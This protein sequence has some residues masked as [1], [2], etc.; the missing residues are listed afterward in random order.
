MR[1]KL[2]LLFTDVEVEESGPTEEDIG[3]IIRLAVNFREADL[4]L[5]S[6]QSSPFLESLR[7]TSV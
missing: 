7:F 2:R 3:R 4:I 5:N 1:R 6:Q